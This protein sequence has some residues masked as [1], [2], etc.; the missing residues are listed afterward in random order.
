LH[1]KTEI[2]HLASKVLEHYQK[3]INEK[4]TGIKRSEIN[5]YPEYV[6]HGKEKLKSIVQAKRAAEALIQS[7]RDYGYV[8]VSS[9]QRGR[10]DKSKPREIAADESL[11]PSER[12]LIK[13]SLVGLVS[14]LPPL[15]PPFRPTDYYQDLIANF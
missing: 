2:E 6:R 8:E 13:P 15:S 4:L 1:D 14:T 11:M 5:N 9:C 12:E 3:I 7:Y 10:L